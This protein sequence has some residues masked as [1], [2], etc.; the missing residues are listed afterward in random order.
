LEIKNLLIS[1][2]S[3]KDLLKRNQQDLEK[4]LK[5]KRIKKAISQASENIQICNLRL[6]VSLHSHVFS[7]N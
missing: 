6:K 5:L 2:E 3:K 4:K 1:K 7:V